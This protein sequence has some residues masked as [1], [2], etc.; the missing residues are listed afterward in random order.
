[1]QL[2]RSC[3]GFTPVSW[4]LQEPENTIE[5]HIMGLRLTEEADASAEKPR[6]MVFEC[7]CFCCSLE[8]KLWNM[9]WKH[10]RSR[11]VSPWTEGHGV[12]FTYM[13]PQTFTSAICAWR[14][15]MAPPSSSTLREGQKQHCPQ[16][17]AW[18]SEP[19]GRSN[20]GVK[21]LCYPTQQ[22]IQAS[23]SAGW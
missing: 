23:W 11:S 8:M 1:M 12:R 21:G 5:T 17:H 3:R 9:T 6:M 15:Q 19:T 7:G 18:H 10:S 13:S 22:A 20:L 2:E 14:T 16:P 4:M